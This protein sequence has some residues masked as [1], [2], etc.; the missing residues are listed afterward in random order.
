MSTLA[1]SKRITLDV[2]ADRYG[3]SVATLRRAI[4]RGDLPAY[5]LGARVL[6]VEEADVAALFERVQSAGDAQ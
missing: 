6:R 2:A 1:R 5:R 4:Y 3:V